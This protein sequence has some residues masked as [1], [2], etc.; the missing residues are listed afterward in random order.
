MTLDKDDFCK[1]V[2]NL[3]KMIEG[4]KCC[5]N[6]VNYHPYGHCRAKPKSSGYETTDANLEPCEMWI[7]RPATKR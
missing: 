5:A 4:L 6:C 1:T 7:Y 3:N 2:I